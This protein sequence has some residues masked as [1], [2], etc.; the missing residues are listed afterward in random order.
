MKRFSGTLV[1]CVLASVFTHAQSPAPF[2]LGTFDRA[3]RTFVGIVL[4]ESVVIDFPTAH[5]AIRAPA[6][7]VAAPADMKDL[8]AR[9]DSGLR[10]RI[11]D[12]VQ[13]VEQAGAARPAYVYDVAAVKVL[14]PIM[15]PTTM[16]NVAVNYAAHDQE[17][18][19][20]REQVPGMG[21]AT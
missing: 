4:R 5:Q 18:A 15:Y 6:S 21:A 14:P 11:V 12:I 9:Y 16:L 19:Q 2:K 7:T 3:G 10:T 20:L 17:M 13:S 1:A 8:I